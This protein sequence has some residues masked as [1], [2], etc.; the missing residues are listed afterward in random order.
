[1]DF[2]LAQLALIKKPIPFVQP[3]NEDIMA[4]Y[5]MLRDMDENPALLLRVD[6][7]RDIYRKGQASVR[8]LIWSLLLVGLVFTVTTLLLLEKLV[9]SRLARLSSDVSRIGASSNLRSRV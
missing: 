1:M 3:L 6:V 4:G 9:L 5:T 7:P 8:Y 2:R